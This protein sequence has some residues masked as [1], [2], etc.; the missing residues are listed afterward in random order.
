[1]NDQEIQQLING[2]DAY[3]L[4]PEADV[5]QPELDYFKVNKVLPTSLEKKVIQSTVPESGYADKDINQMIN[6]GQATIV[7]EKPKGF[8]GKTADLLGDFIGKGTVEAPIGIIKSIQSLSDAK[9]SID[10]Q[11]AGD[12]ELAKLYADRFRQ[13][14]QEIDAISEDLG[15]EEGFGAQAFK[16]SIGSGLKT[17]AFLIP[18]GTVGKLALGSF[19]FSI[20]GQLEEDKDLTELLSFRTA[21]ETG[22]G[23]I[24]PKAGEKVLGAAERYIGRALPERLV[25]RALR[26][27]PSEIAAGT[28]AEQG[29]FVAPVSKTVLDKPFWGKNSIEG[30]YKESD[31]II[32][33][34]SKHVDKILKKESSPLLDSIY[35]LDISEDIIKPLVKN[36]NRGG[37]E[38]TEEG[39]IKSLS[40]ALPT[41]SGLLKDRLLLDQTNILRK[42]IDQ[43]LGDRAFKQQFLPFSKRVLL[44]MRNRLSE[45]IKDVVP[46]TVPLFKTLSKEIRLRDVLINAESRISGKSF[47]T[48]KDVL[49]SLGGLGAGY[50]ADDNKPWLSLV[51]FGVSKG[52]DSPTATIAFA[53]MLYKLENRL[54]PALKNVPIQSR[55]LIEQAISEMF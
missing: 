33:E 19:S 9:K 7:P 41:K 8:W 31:D 42:E 47:I 37:G 27:T 4:K 25:N 10:A 23:T 20:G 15:L 55:F 14:G 21:I 26:L 50:Y 39:V 49:F 18:G 29:R 13:K 16:E 24:L 17:A 22:V 44:D 35:T 5:R 45:F 48:L 54:G 2:G 38:L 32:L 51:G 43:V 30:M 53:K 12:T 36:I 11:K 52:V 1:M 28:K 40:K 6:S 46:E 34:T 3:L